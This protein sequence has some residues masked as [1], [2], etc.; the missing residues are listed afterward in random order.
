MIQCSTIIPKKPLKYPVFLLQT[1]RT[2]LTLQTLRAVIPIAGLGTRL[3]PF[4]KVIPKAMLPV[5]DKPCVQWI[6]EELSEAGV[7]D[8]IF[9]YSKGQEMVKEYFA[10]KTWY[11]E[12]LKKRGKTEGAK[13]L[14]EVRELATFH[15]VEQKEQLGDGHAVL[16]ARNLIPADEAFLVFFGDC[17]YN[18]E[19]VIEE[20]KTQY[21]QTK[22][23]VLA[24]QEVKLEEAQLYGII[25][26][27]SDGKIKTMIEKPTPVQTQDL[28]SQP[29]AIIGRYLL[30]PTIWSHLEQHHSSSGEIRLI[31]A[32]RELQSE[33][34]VY[35]VQLKGAWLDTG[36]FEG[37]QKAST[38][39]K[40]QNS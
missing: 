26:T 1:L 21:E 19:N 30:T 16:Q 34:D 13:K 11:D 40:S 6:V 29:H 38:H 28:A 39:Y 5:Y 37:I 12:E 18:G 17:L 24:T 33:E 22:S 10:E 31:D 2:L 32:L 7:K 3:L 20:L 15:F 14:Q 36:T 35:G 25:T 27:D 4:T 9:V 8:I 23:C